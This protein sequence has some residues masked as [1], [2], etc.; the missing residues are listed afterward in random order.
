MIS[1]K[2]ATMTSRSFDPPDFSISAQML[3]VSGAFPVFN[4]FIALQFAVAF[5]FAFAPLTGRECPG[6]RGTEVVGSEGRGLE[7]HALHINMDIDKP[8]H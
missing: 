5:A 8:F 3:F 1:L 6:P 7:Y 4:C 2:H